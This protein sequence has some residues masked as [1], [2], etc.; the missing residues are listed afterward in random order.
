MLRKL[1]RL[2][3][4]P[5]L[6]VQYALNNPRTV[7]AIAL[8]LV[9][10]GAVLVASLAL[11]LLPEW[12]AVLAIAPLTGYVAYRQYGRVD[13]LVAASETAAGAVDSGVV[14]VS[15]TA[16]PA[17]PDDGVTPRVGEYDGEYLAYRYKENV[18]RDPNDEEPLGGAAGTDEAAAVPFYVEDDTGSVLVDAN[19]ADVMLDW[20]EKD[21]GARRNTYWAALEAGDPI[22]VYGTA[23]APG[24]WEPQT[25]AGA[26]S[27][28][29]DAGRRADVET[30]AADEDV[31]VARSEENP[32]LVVSDRSG[33][34]LM[35]RQVLWLGVAA[36][37]TAV[38]VV[39]AVASMLGFVTL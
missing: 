28:L 20:D 35:G 33:L 37:A 11:G 13:M 32:Y 36:G 22:H 6:A 38:L 8:A 12:L 24:Q 26:V 5:L 19:D 7:A 31:I 16:R 27:D 39:V 21:R 34:E 15:G 30:Y 17:D 10:V 25:A 2:Q 14:K 23:M 29:V 3:R 4:N 1:Q 18:D 9:A